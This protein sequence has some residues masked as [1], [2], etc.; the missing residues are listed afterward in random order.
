[1]A[2]LWAIVRKKSN[3]E[4]ISWLGGGAIIAIGGLWALF[5]YVFP[6]KPPEDRDKPRLAIEATNGGIAIGGNVTNSN[7][8]AGSPTTY[9]SA[10][11]KR[12]ARP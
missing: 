1:M 2:T 5:V 8:T 3:R 4:I 6:P 12:E 7:V 9:G 10:S 11:S